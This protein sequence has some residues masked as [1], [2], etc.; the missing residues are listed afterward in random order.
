MDVSCL[1]AGALDTMSI[2]VVPRHAANNK[3]SA[4]I[5]NALNSNKKVPLINSLIGSQQPFEQTFRL[6][7]RLPR[8]QLFVARMSARTPLADILQHVCD[9]KNLDPNKYEFRHPGQ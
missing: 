6:Q 5:N 8:N 1:I 3:N 7:V 9:E 4:A 2:R